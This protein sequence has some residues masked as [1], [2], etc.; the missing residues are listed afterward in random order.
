[1]TKLCSMTFFHNISKIPKLLVIFPCYNE[2]EILEKCYKKFYIYFED[3]IFRDIINDS[4]RI[5]FVDDGSVD[6]TWKIIKTLDSTHVNALKLS[7]NFGHQKAL[8]AGLETNNGRFD[9]YVT[10]DMDLQDDFTVI[11][12]MLKEI[13]KGADIV[14]GVR[15][16]R[17]HDSFFKRKSAEMFYS[18]MS[19]LGV[20]TFFNHADFRLINNKALNSFLEFT[21]AHLFL[22]AIFPAV[23]LRSSVVYYTRG[24]REAGES[25]YPLKKMI[26]F[27]WDGITSFSVKPLRYILMV[28]LFSTFIAMILI[29]WATVDLIIGKTIPGWF[30]M[31]A[32][33]MFFGGIQT[34]AIGI[35]GEYVGKIFMQV[36]NRPRYIIEMKIDREAQKDKDSAPFQFSG[37]NL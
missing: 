6:D 35:I 32:V 27:A 17:S 8:L 25:K 28:G 34:F 19:F 13:R 5:C 30:S 23:G 2:E 11:T 18:L 15:N 33:I 36:K 21:E 24:K 1:M 22:R 10:L 14:Y 37:S 26:S 9:A 12:K 7:T 20:K 16:N 29:I 4:S 3:L 31:M